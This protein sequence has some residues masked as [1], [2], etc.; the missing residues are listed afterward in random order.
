VCNLSYGNKRIEKK[1]HMNGTAPKLV[2]LEM[3]PLVTKESVR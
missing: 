1:F 3:A 2:F